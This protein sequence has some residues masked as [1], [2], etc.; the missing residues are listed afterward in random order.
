MQNN[1]DELKERNRR[2]W[3]KI[4]SMLCEKQRGH[5]Y[6]LDNSG[7]CDECKLA[8]YG[9]TE[10]KDCGTSWSTSLCADHQSILEL[11]RSNH[12]CSLPKWRKD[13]NM[14]RD[15]NWPAIQLGFMGGTIVSM[16]QSLRYICSIIDWFCDSAENGRTGEEITAALTALSSNIDSTKRYLG[17]GDWFTH[18]V[19]SFMTSTVM[20][21]H[22]I[23]YDT[24]APIVA[25]LKKF[26]K[27]RVLSLGSGR[28]FWECMMH[29]MGL[30]VT[31]VDECPEFMSFC[32]FF[33][34]ITWIESD[35]N[36]V[37]DADYDVIFMSWGRG[38]ATL[39]RLGKS[40]L[41]RGGV[42]LIIGEGDGGC[43][44]PCW[45]HFEEEDSPYVVHPIKIPVY[46]GI[47]DVLSITG[48]KG[49]T[50]ESIVTSLSAE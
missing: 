17:G 13:L 8:T 27:T 42:V 28:G 37:A 33:P 3:D 22:V 46:G 35:Y 11:A 20:W 6:H 45:E 36:S 16:H 49:T 5:E 34:E 7:N 50:G 21:T 24:W 38:T 18:D 44:S 4:T 19:R 29:L 1:H 9:Y 12:K 48:Q 23:P 39:D 47:H 25:A 15:M 43:T 26:G 14:L 31:C 10:C 2:E 30:T 41:A 40:V 32:Q